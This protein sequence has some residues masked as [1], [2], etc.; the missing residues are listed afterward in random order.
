MLQRERAG[1]HTRAHHHRHEARTFLVGP[2]HDF[3]RRER[4]H[5]GIGE[6]AQYFETRQHAVVAVELAARR[7]RVDVA[8]GHHRRQVVAQTRAARED[9]ADRVDPH[10]AAD[11]LRPRD[12]QVACLAVQFRQCEPAHT[13][14]VGGADLREF[15]ETVPEPGAIDSQIGG[16]RDGC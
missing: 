3:Q 15:H 2:H 10:A 7:L 12:K 8:A 11:L 14:L 9:I 5:V 4:L 6:R 16:R 1:E 13:A